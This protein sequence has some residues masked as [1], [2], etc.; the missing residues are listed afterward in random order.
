[1]AVI[2]NTEQLETLFNQKLKYIQTEHQETKLYIHSVLAK[3]VNSNS[4]MS[5]ISVTLQFARAKE[6][7]NFKLFQEL[8]DWLLFAGSFY[9]ESLNG[10]SLDYYYSIAQ[11][12]YSS[13]YYIINKQWPLFLE[14]SNNFPYFTQKINKSL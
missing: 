12:S 3:F 13:C 4:D 10:A 6:Q 11:N 1:M 8:A 14:L 2:I 7:Y 9:P 5:K